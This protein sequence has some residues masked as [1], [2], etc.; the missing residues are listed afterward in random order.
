MNR[1][2]LLCFS[3]HASRFGPGTGDCAED[4]EPDGCAARFGVGGG[5][6]GIWSATDRMK[7]RS[8]KA[9][10]VVRDLEHVCR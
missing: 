3:F 10:S 4:E 9:S 6:L 5:V 7:S 2:L 1:N 8:G